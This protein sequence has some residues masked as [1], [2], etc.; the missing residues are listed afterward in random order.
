MRRVD[1]VHRE[2]EA[3]ANRHGSAGQRN[4]TAVVEGSRDELYVQAAE[5]HVLV[6]VL[7]RGSQGKR[8]RFVF[9][10]KC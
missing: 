2:A 6:A 1:T 7:H 3:V 4:Q 10:S 5:D 9:T 8:P